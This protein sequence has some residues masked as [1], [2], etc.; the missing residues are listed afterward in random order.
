MDILWN[1]LASGGIRNTVHQDMKWNMQNILMY[2]E[3]N[4]IIKGHFQKDMTP[5]TEL[6]THSGFRD[7][8]V[9]VK[10]SNPCFNTL[11]LCILPT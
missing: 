8:P 11:K 6:R 2:N 5:E 4:G 3:L 10:L 9:C 7:R 1:R